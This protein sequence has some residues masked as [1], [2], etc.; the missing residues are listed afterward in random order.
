MS[1]RKTISTV[2]H[3]DSDLEDLIGNGAS[4]SP[5]PNSANVDEDKIPLV[6]KPVETN[7]NKELYSS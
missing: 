7:D 1:Q 2:Q 4:S 3:D 6:G 5:S